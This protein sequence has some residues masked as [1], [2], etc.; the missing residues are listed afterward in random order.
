MKMSITISS[1]CLGLLD[2]PQITMMDKEIE[3][4]IGNERC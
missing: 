3:S 2:I 4:F 1:D